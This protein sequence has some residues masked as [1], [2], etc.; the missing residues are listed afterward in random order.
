MVT[1]EIT[2]FFLPT[3]GA[4]P[5]GIFYFCTSRPKN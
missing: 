2:P 4:L 5:A 3:P 1:I